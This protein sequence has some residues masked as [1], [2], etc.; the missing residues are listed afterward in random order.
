V[1]LSASD[2]LGLF[3]SLNKFMLSHDGFFVLKRSRNLYD[4]L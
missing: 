4:D 3:V 1:R 2:Y